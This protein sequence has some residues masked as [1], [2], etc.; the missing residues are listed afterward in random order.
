[1]VDRSDENND[2]GQAE[3]LSFVVSTDEA[4][5]IDDWSA[6]HHIDDRSEAVHQLVNLALHADEE[7]DDVHLR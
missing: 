6:A 5:A 1:M 3:A 2:A 4:R 7:P